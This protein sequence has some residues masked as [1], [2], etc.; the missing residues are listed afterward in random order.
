MG[1]YASGCYS[2]LLLIYDVNRCVSLKSVLKIPTV[3]LVINSS[4]KVIT[5]S[6]SEA[7]GH[8]L[9]FSICSRGKLNSGFHGLC[10]KE[11]VVSTAGGTCPSEVYYEHA[12]WRLGGLVCGLM[13]KDYVYRTLA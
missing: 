7:V 10:R 4:V 12:G 6:T 2:E 9:Q 11:L 3:V 8:L 5:C 13:H 1:F